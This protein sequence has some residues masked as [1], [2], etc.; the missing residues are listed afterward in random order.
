MGSILSRDE[1]DDTRS[2]FLHF[3]ISHDILRFGSFTLKSG[4]VSP[5][6]F[7]AGLFNTGSAAASLGRWYAQTIVN[8]GSSLEFDALFGPAYKGIP[9]VALV[10][11]QA[12][13]ISRG[14]GVLAPNHENGY[15][16]H[17]GNQQ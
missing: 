5:Y 12:P 7:N 17:M 8:A 16:N 2:A 11:S 15:I 3:S 13:V 1:D 14:G 9:F 6:F 4:R 10:Q